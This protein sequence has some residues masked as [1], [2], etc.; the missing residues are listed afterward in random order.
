MSLT[1]LVQ[2]AQE[3][4][5]AAPD[6]SDAWANGA[7][8]DS[9]FVTLAPPRR[10]RSPVPDWIRDR[11]REQDLP[12]DISHPWRI[13]G[14][15]PRSQPPPDVDVVGPD[16]LAFYIPFHFYRQGWGIFIRMSGVVYLASILKGGE[17]GPGDERFLNVAEAFLH[18]HELFHSAVEIA[19]TRAE[20]LARRAV[21]R[22]SNLKPQ[23]IMK[24][25]WPMPLHFGGAL[26]ITTHS[27]RDLASTAGCWVWVRAIANATDGSRRRPSRVDK[28]ERHN[29]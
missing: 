19:S 16:A 17:L 25:L 23:P 10:P 24:R 28:K 2:F 20:L 22:T 29:S 7:T 12:G 21:C 14:P 13:E 15:L 26:V 6:V 18:E 27:L 3:N 5:A 8:R 4:F 9:D 1:K 11:R